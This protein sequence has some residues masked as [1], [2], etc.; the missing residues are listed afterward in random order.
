MVCCSIQLETD[1]SEV[2]FTN[3]FV[4]FDEAA[5]LS[6]RNQLAPLSQD[7]LRRQEDASKTKN[8]MSKRVKIAQWDMD[9]FL[10]HRS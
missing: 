6:T 9:T 5:E 8:T 1:V 10:T 4:F 3:Q 7:Q 2:V